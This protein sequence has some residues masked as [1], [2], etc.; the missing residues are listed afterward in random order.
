MNSHV[1]Q[2]ELRIVLH[3]FLS[4]ESHLSI[5]VQSCLIHKVARL[6]EHTTAATGRIEH[7]SLR[8]FQHVD[9]H[10]Y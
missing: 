3:L 6:Y 4:I 2:T 8:G 1:H 10:L 7:H 5:S 9:Q